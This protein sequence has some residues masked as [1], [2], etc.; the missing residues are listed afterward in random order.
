MKTLLS[1]AKANTKATEQ[2]TVKPSTFNAIKETNNRY[3]AEQRSL[4]GCLKWLTNDKEF[5]NSIKHD[6]LFYIRLTANSV[7][8]LLGICKTN[9]YER[10]KNR[11]LFTPFTVAQI[12]RRD[13]K[14]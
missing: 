7:F 3:K 8:D 6:E 14:K 2:K 12:L 13:I 9:F 4:M 10:E 11:V 5:L 1:Q